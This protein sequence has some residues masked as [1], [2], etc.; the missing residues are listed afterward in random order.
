MGSPA[1]LPTTTTTP[2]TRVEPVLL[3]IFLGILVFLGALFAAE[4]F[5]PMDGAMFQAVASLLSG[6]AGAF[7]MRVKPRTDTDSSVTTTTGA[8]PQTL[9]VQTSPSTDVKVETTAPA[10]AGEVKE[11]P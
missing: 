5:F 9:T 11:T 1:P 7:L 6:F 3:L 4:T 2:S 10:A 8:P